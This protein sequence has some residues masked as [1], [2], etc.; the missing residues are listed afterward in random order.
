[1][2]GHKFYGSCIY[3]YTVQC[4]VLPAIQDE[5]AARVNSKGTGKLL[6]KQA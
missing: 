5:W 2:L 1:M 4:G 6:S 3:F